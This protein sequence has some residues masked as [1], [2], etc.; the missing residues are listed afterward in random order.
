[1]ISRASSLK[2]TPTGLANPLLD[3]NF[4]IY[5]FLIKNQGVKSHDPERL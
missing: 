3:A 5:I 4:G 1:M 2:K